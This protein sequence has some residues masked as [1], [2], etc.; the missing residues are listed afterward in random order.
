MAGMTELSEFCESLEAFR[1]LPYPRYTIIPDMGDRTA[2]L[3]EL[4]GHI[5]G[6]AIQ[7][8]KGGIEAC[9]I[10]E[11]EDL[12]L[13]LDRTKQRGDRTS[14]PGLDGRHTLR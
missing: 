7:V 10:P 6:Y 14:A 11:M 9:E 1:V 8:G 12:V 4:D 5:A 3:L 2:I 13:E